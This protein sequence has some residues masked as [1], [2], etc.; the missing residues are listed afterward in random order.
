MFSNP[1]NNAWVGHRALVGRPVREAFPEAETDGFLALLDRVYRTGEPFSTTEMPLRLAQPD[2]TVRELF[3]N[4]VYQATR[5]AQGDIDG[6]AGFAFEV[7][8]QVLA[9][10]KIEALAEELQAGEARLRTL[11]ESNIIGI[12]FWDIEGGISEANDA[13]LQSMGYTREDLETGRIDWRQVTP[14]EWR[15]QDEE[16]VKA[17]LETGKHPPAEKEYFRKDGSRFPLIV[18]ST[19]FPGS[20]REGVGFVLDISARRQGE[21]ELRQSEARAQEAAAVARRNRAQLEARG[22]GH[23]A[24][25][26][27]PGPRGPQPGDRGDPAAQARAARGWLARRD[28]HQ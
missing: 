19:F 25:S 11:V 27:N 3:I 16:L 17:L 22:S 13:F 24:R 14:P 20:R 28:A 18:A 8:A 4:F 6:I 7:T 2:G 15:A 1:I 21:A 10:R 12:I 5:D 26:S 23:R 9:R